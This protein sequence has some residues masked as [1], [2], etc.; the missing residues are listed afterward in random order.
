MFFFS[1]W[2]TLF[3]VFIVCFAEYPLNW[4]S[5]TILLINLVSVVDILLNLS[6]FNTVKALIYI[7]YFCSAGILLVNRL[8]KQ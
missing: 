1:P 8:F 7:L 4:K 6:K 3:H 2:F 5:L